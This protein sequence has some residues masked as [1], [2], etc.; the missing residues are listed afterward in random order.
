MLI[1]LSALIRDNPG[2]TV[3]F[4]NLF[5]ETFLLQT[6]S[7]LGTLVHPTENTYDLILTNP[8]YVMSGSSN[9]K[10]EIAKQ[11]ILKR[12]FSISAM[13]IEGLFMEWI[14]RALKPGGKAFVVVPDGIMNRSNDKRLRDFILEE[15]NIDAVISLP[16]NTFFTTNKKTYILAVTKKVPVMR[17][18]IEVK[19]R[20]TSRVFTYLCSEI[21]ETRDVYRFDMEQNDLAEAAGLFNM[22][23][24][25]RDY[26]KTPDKRCKVI[27][28]DAFYTVAHWSV[29]RWW[30]H[31]ERIALGIEEET[32]SVT[33][34]EMG[35]LVGDIANTLL[36]YQDMFVLGGQKKKRELTY[37]AVKLTDEN[38]FSL[39][40]G[41]IGKNRTELQ[42]IDTHNPSDIPVY[43]AAQVPVA[44]IEPLKGRMPIEASEEKPLLSFATNG[45]GSAGRNFVVHT[46]PF[47]LNVDRMV[48]AL[49]D[50]QLILPYLYA[51]ISDMKKKYGFNHSFK[52]NRHNLEN[53]TFSI[54]VSENGDF[55]V[56]AQEAISA[57]FELVGQLKEEI[58]KHREHIN[59]IIVEVDLSGYSMVYK[60]ISEL[61]TIERGR[62]KYTKTYT[63]KH[64][65]KYPLYSGNTFGEFAFIDSYDYD[66]PCLTWA[67]DGLAGYM[68]VHK[69]PFS[70]T[71]HRGILLPKAMDI[72][73]DYIKFT[74]EPLLRQAKKG[75]VGDNGENEYTSLPPFMLNDI[76]VGVPID[77]T[78][79]ISVDLQREIAVSYLAIE[80]YRREI[81]SKLDTLLQQ[82]IEPDFNG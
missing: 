64:L 41:G 35:S 76:E 27:D 63:Q 54:P 77:E 18:G 51:Q 71:N 5:N 49:K 69:A 28:I 56:E 70:A 42:I 25:A 81:L 13:G 21:G 68:M 39:V 44:Y 66:R 29:E 19:E 15:C 50:N 1:Y 9:L 43:T 2:I 7:I 4:A 73:I 10:D 23:K 3:D 17:D 14:I 72:D 24:G 26:F 48:V 12:Y 34:E 22:F 11:D 45:D 53:V 47:Y 40:S 38:S 74:L 31:E 20:Q 65:G 58:K 79:A 6:N 57:Q 59:S 37:K 62:G 60:T 78:G 32:E 55:D 61:F 67:I 16:I 36:E 52:A 33:M 80:Q 82:R 30:T 8:P 75:R 46:A